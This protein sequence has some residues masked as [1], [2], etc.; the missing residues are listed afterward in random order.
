MKI[1][2]SQF[3]KKV[4]EYAP[5]SAALVQPNSSNTG[6]KKTPKEYIYPHFIAKIIEESNTTK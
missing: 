1:L 5:D 2:R 6:L 3:K 4:S